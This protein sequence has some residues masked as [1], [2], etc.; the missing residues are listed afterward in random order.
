MG[1][2]N[3]GIK[4]KEF[5]AYYFGSHCKL[6]AEDIIYLKCFPSA[7]SRMYSR[8]LVEKDEKIEDNAR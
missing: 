1:K 6:S 2:L 3:G 7:R 4:L 5:V 8:S